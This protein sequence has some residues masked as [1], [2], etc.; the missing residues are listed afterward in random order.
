LT[1]CTLEF[2]ET[3]QGSGVSASEIRAVSGFEGLVVDDSLNVTVQVGASSSLVTIHADDNLLTY[4]ST[5]LEGGRLI[6]AVQDGYRLDPTPQIEVRLPILTSLT[7]AGSGRVQL[8]G[9]WGESLQLTLAGSG[10]LNA[11]GRV[12][13]LDVRLVGSGDLDLFDLSADRVRIDATGSGD[14][15]LFARQELS[16][17]RFGSGDVVYRGAPAVTQ[18][19]FGSGDVRPAQVHEQVSEGR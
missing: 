7:Y 11:S 16:V 9:V 5:E 14:V 15:R 6:L 3:V 4:V 8:E 19:S 13:S 18:K 2:E 1:A 10:D 12:A 17:R